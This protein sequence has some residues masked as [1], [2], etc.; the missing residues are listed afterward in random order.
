MLRGVLGTVSWRA[1]QM[2]PQFAPDVS[3]LLSAAAQA[4]GARS[5][6]R[7]QVGPRHT[8]QSL[9]FHSFNETPC[10]SWFLLRGPMRSIVPDQMVLGQE[11]MRQLC[12][13]KSC[14]DMVKKTMSA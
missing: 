7:Q 1:Q 10:I 4:R 13:Q 9:H 3:L 14:S 8:S 12:L 6:G 2:S 5:S 11:V